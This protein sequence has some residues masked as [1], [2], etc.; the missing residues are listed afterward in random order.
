[1]V[2][3]KRFNP[4]A[5]KLSEIFRIFKSV[6]RSWDQFEKHLSTWS[7]CRFIQHYLPHLFQLHH[8]PSFFLILMP[9]SFNLRAFAYATLCLE[10]CP[11][12]QILAPSL[13]FDGTSSQRPCQGQQLP[14]ALPSN[15]FLSL[16]FHSQHLSR[17]IIILFI[18]Y[19]TLPFPSLRV[20]APGGLE[21]CLFPLFTVCRENTQEIFVE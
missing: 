20:W 21:P 7:F 16:L 17:L 3:I 11:V 10:L 12:S 9:I 13:T 19:F 8:L 6:R 14:Q 2:N 15:S 5:H 18:C 1:M 4:G